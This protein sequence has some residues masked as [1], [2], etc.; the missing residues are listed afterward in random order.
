[1]IVIGKFSAIVQNASYREFS[2]KERPDK[3]Y[4]LNEIEFHSRELGISGILRDW[5]LSY[6]TS[7]LPNGTEIIVNYDSCKPVKGFSSVFEFGGFVR[8]ISNNKKS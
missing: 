2:S 5:T 1:M 3:T 4:K 8:I 6:P 7:E